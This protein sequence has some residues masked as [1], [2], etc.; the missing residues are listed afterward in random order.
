MARDEKIYDIIQ[1]ILND[2]Y[3]NNTKSLAVNATSKAEIESMQYN[4][5]TSAFSSTTVHTYQYLF[6]GL[7]LKFSTSASKNITLSITNG[8]QSIPIWSKTADTATS[9]VWS[10]DRAFHLP[11]NWEIKLEIT[12]TSSACLADILVLGSGV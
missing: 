6:G 1:Q 10:P 9:R 3:L 11:A 4:L 5:L 7:F 2:I 12:Q 8:T